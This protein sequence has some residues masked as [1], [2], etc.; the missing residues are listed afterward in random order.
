MKLK[1]LHTSRGLAIALLILLSGQ[2]LMANAH[3]LTKSYVPEELKSIEAKG[4]VQSVEQQE[5]PENMV[6]WMGWKSSGE[7]LNLPP[8]AVNNTLFAAPQPLPDDDDLGDG[9]SIGGLLDEEIK[10]VQRAR[11]V[12]AKL[13]DTGNFLKKFTGGDLVTFP[14]GVSEELGAVT[15][16][17]GIG[18]MRLYP[19]YSELEVYLEIDAPGFAQPLLFGSNNIK[20]TKKGGIV[21]DAR[22]GLM[23]DFFIPM[24]KG[25][26]GIILRKMIKGTDD[27]CYV[28]ISCD[29][30]EELSLDAGVLFSRDWLLP[31][32]A[33]GDVLPAPKRVE[34]NIQT[35]LTDWEELVVEVD[36]FTPFQVKGVEDVQWSVQNMIFDF[37]DV[38]TPED[39]AFPDTYQSPY[40]GGG[41]Y[42]SPLWKGFYL[43]SLTLTLP[44]KVTNK[45]DVTI[46]VNDVIIDETGFTG[47]VFKDNILPL[48]EGN[49]DGW[50]F[51][52]DYLELSVIQQQFNYIDFNGQI[53]VPLINS[54]D[55]SDKTDVLKY[56]AFI[57]PG[58]EYTMTVVTEEEYPI[59]MW[60]A[61]ITLDDGSSIKFTY[62]DVVDKMSAEA[63]LNGTVHVDGDFGVAKLDIP[64]IGFNELKVSTQAPH[65]TVGSID[66]PEQLGLKIAGFS[67]SIEDIE[68]PS[69]DDNQPILS[70][71]VDLQLTTQNGNS[72]NSEEDL[73]I[74]AEGGFQLIGEFVTSDNGTQKWKQKSLVIDEFLIDANFQGVNKIKG[75]LSIQKNHPTYGDYFKGVIDIDFEGLGVDVAAVGQFGNID[76]ET[77]NYKYF[78]V[79]ALAT[80]E[81]GIGP[82]GPLTIKGFGG[83][84]YHHMTRSDNSDLVAAKFGD[85]SLE[86]DPEDS[87]DKPDISDLAPGQS[88]SGVSYV[89]DKDTKLGVRVAAVVAT[90]SA[91]SAFNGNV[92]FGIEFG[93]P[94]NNPNGINVSRVYFEGNGRFMSELVMTQTPDYEEGSGDDAPVPSIDASISAY[95]LIDYKIQD[96]EFSAN[97]GINV[98]VGDVLT[99]SGGVDVFIGKNDDDEEIW[100]IKAGEPTPPGEAE[101]RNTFD[102]NVPLANS[103][104]IKFKNYFMMGHDLPPMPPPPSYFEGDENPPAIRD[105]DTV[106]TEG[107]AIGAS[108]EVNA[109]ISFLIIYADLN[110]NL[111]FDIALNNLSNSICS[112]SGTAPGINGWYASGQAWAQLGLDLGAQIKIFGKKKKFPL[113]KMDAGV[114]VQA[115]LPNP[116]WAK[117]QVKVEATVLGFVNINVDFEAEIGE[118]CELKPDFENIN[119]IR[120]ITPAP[121]VE[122]N[123][124]TI[125]LV[126][127]S[128]AEI[129]IVNFEIPLEQIYTISEDDGTD[130]TGTYQILIEHITVTANGQNV[131]SNYVLSEDG[132]QAEVYPGVF[133]E[134]TGSVY[135]FLPPNANVT[136]TAKVYF[137]ERINGEW[138][139]VKDEN[140]AKEIDERSV[141]FQT[142]DMPEVILPSN[143]IASYPIDRQYNFYRNESLQGGVKLKV[144]QEYLY[145]GLPN[146]YKVYSRFTQVD[147]PP[148]AGI[149]MPTTYD[150]GSNGIAFGIPTNNLLKKNK[151]YKMDLVVL[152]VGGIASNNEEVLYTI[153]FR[154][155]SYNKLNNK[156]N[157]MIEGKNYTYNSAT[158]TFPMD[159]VPSDLNNLEPFDEFELIGGTTFEPLIQWEGILIGNNW[160]KNKIKPL[161][162]D[163]FP[164]N[165]AGISTF[166]FDLTKRKEDPYG[167]PPIHTAMIVQSPELIKLTNAEIEQ[168]FANSYSDLQVELSYFIRNIMYDDYIDFKTQTNDLIQDFVY[169]LENGTIT[170]MING[171]GKPI[172]I[173]EDLW[174]L[175]TISEFITSEITPQYIDDL[176]GSSFPN[177][178]PETYKLQGSYHPPV[179]NSSS[180]TKI[181]KIILN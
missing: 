20:F 158:G 52:I 80:F 27:G 137:Q 157:K 63:I 16:T 14:V 115:K 91:S 181:I 89:L 110:A 98:A 47:K 6:P 2:M 144:S 39:V 109:D 103:L 30:F 56:T 3:S 38:R 160:Y 135:E 42:V 83:G 127:V 131:P 44:K 49:V 148:S 165:E 178:I 28:N 128:V 152:P 24:S 65:L 173:E 4:V 12:I 21:G 168:G 172:N 64:D 180:S 68:F 150:T 108:L 36:D 33:N 151:I 79:D 145:E 159:L 59:D 117:G 114:L 177:P 72:G 66:E 99:G 129:P 67:L 147:L 58:N 140:G 37:S 75:G 119:V 46:G 48:N 57:D 121:I 113:F 45:P 8:L 61:T 60:L 136:V 85:S 123:G 104:N 149:V 84:I 26:S 10:A 116:F 88:L 166:N 76:T 134:A 111:G 53:Q 101:R 143:V 132:M 179:L 118:K 154:T 175:F 35:I 18:G 86:V 139:D 162:Y 5:V 94:E 93:T 73:A 170:D 55:P 107:F 126:D 130:D 25:K 176:L 54:E 1:I 62:D 153:H 32:D 34:G 146:N 50:A 105:A 97:L 71:N 70:F 155:S 133:S 164:N 95:V 156:I 19:T 141:S 122:S 142:G 77:E 15:Y 81:P 100:Y 138:Y 125:P 112:G 96:K 23:S 78:F 124:N 167:V 43:E 90:E 41:E 171:E 161:I 31:L 174:D 82:I 120:S 69:N 102:I 51:S 92:T 22:L 29:G 163:H 169:G 11:E 13:K 40:W 17:M 7:A 9:G 87:D 74:K 106:L